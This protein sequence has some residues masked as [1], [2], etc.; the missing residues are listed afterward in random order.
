MLFDIQLLYKLVGENSYYW[1]LC[2]EDRQEVLQQAI[3]AI[4]DPS[5]YARAHTTKYLVFDMLKHPPL[6]PNRSS[7]NDLFSFLCIKLKEQI[8]E[9]LP[10][11][12][13]YVREIESFT[14]INN[15]IIIQFKEGTNSNV[16]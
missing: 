14:L 7:V 1:G 2:K 12:N 3:E 6:E 11:Q 9:H 15:L 16:L 8:L 5:E 13:G 10:G 4:T